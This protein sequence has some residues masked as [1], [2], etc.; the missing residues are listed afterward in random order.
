ME[1][2]LMNPN[3]MNPGSHVNKKIKYIYC[4]FYNLNIYNI[5]LEKQYTR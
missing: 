1:E 3:E 5:I 2:T 4:L